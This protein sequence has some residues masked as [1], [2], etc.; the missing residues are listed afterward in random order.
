[1][2]FRVKYD[3]KTTLSLKNG[4]VYDVIKEETRRKGFWRVIDE[5]GEDYVYTLNNFVVVEDK[6]GNAPDYV[7]R[8]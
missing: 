6:A 8:S 7:R 4:A 3:G 5:T 1:M 2:L